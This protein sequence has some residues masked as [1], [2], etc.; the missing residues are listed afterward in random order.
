VEL[1]L[2]DKVAVVTGASAGIGLAIAHGLAAEGV[3]LVMAAR[4]PA[5]LS[6]AGAKIAE[7]CGVR[8]ISVAGDVGTPDGAA[9]LVAAAE[10]EFGGADILINNAGTGSNE[11]IP[12]P[13][14]R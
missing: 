2:R 9:S 1:G 5:R 3:H 14:V 11:T 10:G 8:V 7:R 4:D 12:R 13:T 6:D